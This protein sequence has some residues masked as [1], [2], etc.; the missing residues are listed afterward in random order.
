MSVRVVLRRVDGPPQAQARE[1]LLRAAAQATGRP[2]ESIRVAY[3]PDGRPYLPGIAL[4]VSVSHTEGAAAVALSELAPVGVDVEAVRPLPAIA[5]ARRWLPA[6]EA[7][8]IAALPEHRRAVAFLRLWTVKEAIGKAHGRGLHGGAGLR[9]PVPTTE[10][11]HTLRPLPDDP[12][13]V[14]STLPAPDDLVLAVACH[15]DQAVRADL[16]IA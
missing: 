6:A 12:D 5:L 1:L 14:A 7:E 13:T 2:V 3:E 11:G 4:H 16:V 15:S 9:R 8:W 10:P